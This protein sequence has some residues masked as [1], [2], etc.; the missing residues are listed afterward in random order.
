[1]TSPIQSLTLD[2]ALDSSELAAFR[3]QLPTVHVP[4]AGHTPH[5]PQTSLSAG[6]QEAIQIAVQAGLDPTGA[7]AL[8]LVVG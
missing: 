7:T 2:Q 3:H 5:S 6:P 1:M 8:P 4:F